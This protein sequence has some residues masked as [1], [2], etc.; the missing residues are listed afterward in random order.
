MK[1]KRQAA[2]IDLI[3]LHQIGTQEEMLARLSE[4]GFAVTQATVSRDIRELGLFK[5]VAENGKTCYRSVESGAR[6]PRFGNILNDSVLS[7]TSAGN[8]VVVR[9]HPGLAG[10]VAAFIDAQ[11]NFTYL[12]SVAGDDTVLAV[13]ETPQKAATLAEGLRMLAGMY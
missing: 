11:N 10:A 7:I 13:A 2:I 1:R 3:A 5:V 6:R 12:G 4:S 8:L 9:T